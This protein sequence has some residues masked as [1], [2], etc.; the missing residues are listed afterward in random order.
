MSKAMNVTLFVPTINELEG[1]KV[2]MAQVPKELFCQILISDGNSS[3]GTVEWA[4]SMGFDVYVQ[5]KA[6]LRH[7]YIEAWSMIKG[8][9]VVTFSPDGNCI[10]AALPLIVAKLKEG[11]DMV[12]ASRYLGEAKSEDDDLITGFGNWIFTKMIN[13]LHGGSYTDSLG[14]YR[15]YRTSLFYELD[16]DKEESWKDEKYFCTVVGIEPL[17]SI[18]AAK[19]KIKITEIPS[20][21]PKRT[22]GE[23]KLQIFRWGAMQLVHTIKEVFYWKK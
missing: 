4:R 20:D 15:G 22:T 19:K 8:D 21:E 10:P 17:L 13:V 9:Y 12:I 2:Q 23:R 1:L 11:Y 6:G 7:A 5:K 16:L 18:R 3:D 14:I